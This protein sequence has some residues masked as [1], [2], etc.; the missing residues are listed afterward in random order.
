VLGQVRAW[1]GADARE[2]LAVADAGT[3]ASWVVG[4]Q[5]LADAVAVANLAAVAV[6]DAHGDGQ[7]LHGAASTQAWI[8]GAC[9]VSGAEA[10]ERVR[11]ARAARGF[12]GGAVSKVGEGLLTYDHLRAVERGVRHIRQS[13]QPA[14]VTVLTDLAEVGSVTDVR[15]AGKHLQYV[16]DP[17]GSLAN[18]CQ[19]FD[20]RY[21]TLAPLLDGMTAV[22]GLLDA[23]AAA[24]V[25]AAL[26]PF[27]VP[28]DATDDRTASQRRADGLVQIVASAADQALLPI[29]GGER[30]HLHVIV[31]PRGPASGVP[32]DTDPATLPP[33]RLPQTPG[34]PAF[35]HPS[36]VARIGCDAQLTALLLDEHGVVVDLGRTRRLFSPQQ[37]RLLSLRDR[38]CRFPGCDRPPAHTDA[39]HLLPWHEGGATDL[40]NAL[41]LCRHHHRAVHEGKW[42]LNTA[43]PE[44]GTH[45]PITVT[46]P[47]GQQLTSHP[48]AP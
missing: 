4:L 41:L 43:N 45:G 30:P 20:R 21:L 38:G 22:D 17:D 37:R 18:S 34:G 13:R 40:A 47:T 8:R 39:H 5:Q 46:S 24:L 27:L 29:V 32:G 9:R 19:Q 44:R 28:A 35:I 16:V 14:A 33:G 36:G 23:E 6:F 2:A 3:R 48:R 26:E 42:T 12:L 10:A 15:T 11:I 7:T 1:S 25:T 31:D